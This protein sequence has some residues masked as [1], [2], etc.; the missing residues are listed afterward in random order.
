MHAPPYPESL[1]GRWHWW[2]P[3]SGIP[4]VYRRALTQASSDKQSG[5]SHGHDSPLP[6]HLPL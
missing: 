3:D 1:R 5:S 2:G 4:L 6:A